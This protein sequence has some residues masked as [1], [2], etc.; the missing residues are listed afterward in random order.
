MK[1]GKLIVIEGNDGSGKATQAKLLY[2]YL[3]TKKIAPSHPLSLNKSWV[4]M[5]YTQ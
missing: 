4:Q 3:H 2:E 1:R 5:P